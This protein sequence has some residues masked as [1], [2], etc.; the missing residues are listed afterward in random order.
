MSTAI[1]AF[2]RTEFRNSALTKIRTEGNIPAVVYGNNVDSTSIYIDGAD[3]TKTMREVGRNGVFPLHLN[4]KKFNVI[5]TDYQADPIKNAIVHV[6]LLAVDMSK[7]INADVRISLMGD[8][9]GVKDGGVLQQA[10]HEI[11]ITATPTDIPQAIEIDVSQLEVGETITIAD[12]KR[13]YDFAINHEDEQTI[14]S[15]LP[16]KQE[17]EIDSG[18]EQAEGIPENEEGRETEPESSNE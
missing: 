14:A 16:P 4:G 2:E 6:D 13:Q 1:Q 18:E 15:I 8:A 17:A 11:S 3:F 10:L 9:Q 12:I 7:E 5:L